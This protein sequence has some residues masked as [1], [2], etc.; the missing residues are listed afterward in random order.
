MMSELMRRSSGEVLVVSFEASESMTNWKLGFSS[1][2]VAEDLSL[3]DG[4]LALR[5]RQQLQSR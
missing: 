5:Q 3:G 1:A 2:V 4:Y